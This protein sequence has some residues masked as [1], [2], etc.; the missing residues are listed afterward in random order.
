MSRNL[1]TLIFLVSFISNIRSQ[2]IQGFVADSSNLG[3]YGIIV[4]AISQNDTTKRKDTL[5]D[6]AGAYILKDIVTGINDIPGFTGDKM[7]I[8]YD[9]GQMRINVTSNQNI[10]NGKLY[11]ITGQAISGAQFQRIGSN[12][13]QAIMNIPGVPEQAVL[14][15]DGVH[16]AKKIIPKMLPGYGT[17]PIELDKETEKSRLK[18]API[19]EETNFIFRLDDP[20]EVDEYQPIEVVKS[21]DMQNTNYFDFEMQKWPEFSSNIFFNLEDKYG[22]TQKNTNININALDGTCSFNLQTDNNGAAQITNITIPH[23][24]GNK[25]IPDS[26]DFAVEI[27]ANDYLEMTRDTLIKV[28][29]GNLI[30]NYHNL[31]P[32]QQDFFANNYATIVS[33]QTGNPLQNVL[34]EMWKENSTDT[35]KLVSNEQGKVN[36]ENLVIPPFNE[37]TPDT[38]KYYMQLSKD[39]YVSILDSIMISDGDYV[40]NRVLSTAYSEYSIFINSKN[41][42]QED[43]NEVEWT[44]YTPDSIYVWSGNTGINSSDTVEIIIPSSYT[45]VKIH[46]EKKYYK[47][48]DSKIELNNSNT[49]TIT[50]NEFNANIYSVSI[51]SYEGALVNPMINYKLQYTDNEIYN[52]IN[53]ITN[54]NGYDSISFYSYNDSIQLIISSSALHFNSF[55]DTVIIKHAFDTIKVYNSVERFITILDIKVYGDSLLQQN[56]DLKIYFKNIS[57]TIVKL[58]DTITRV[59]ASDVRHRFIFADFEGFKLKGTYLSNS[60]TSTARYFLNVYLRSDCSE[61]ILGRGILQITPIYQWSE[62][63]DVVI[64][65]PEMNYTDSFTLID[66]NAFKKIIPVLDSG[67]TE[68][69]LNYYPKHTSSDKI[70]FYNFHKTVYVEPNTYNWGNDT[71][72]ALEQQQKIK[73]K[74]IYGDTKINAT[75]VD[76]IVWNTDKTQVVD[77]I[78]TMNGEFEFGPYSVGFSGFMDIHI[79]ESHPERADTLY[80][81]EKGIPLY[82]AD[83]SNATGYLIPIEK[84]TNFSDSIVIYNVFLTPAFWIDAETGMLAKVNPAHLYRMFGT[85]HAYDLTLLLDDT[86]NYYYV[87]IND[88]K[89][90]ENKIY[91]QNVVKEIENDFG[92]SFKIKEVHSKFNEFI[93]LTSRPS[94]EGYFKPYIDSLKANNLIGLNIQLGGGLNYGYG[95]VNFIKEDVWTECVQ[96]VRIPLPFVNPNDT[97]DPNIL[98]PYKFTTYCRE[99]IHR[100]FNATN[101]PE[102]FYISVGNR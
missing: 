76:I 79:P 16:P 8:T 13:F 29:Q 30:K 43:L 18:S 15:S 46:S 23:I 33:E 53:G 11:T 64:E 65:I 9:G 59:Y 26:I 5:T 54:I 21:V 36:F 82:K 20:Q 100:R 75:Y 40:V 85:G 83:Y 39:G 68:V 80:F 97:R 42:N 102:E 72:Q 10:Q 31:T 12:E 27:P 86:I 99:F 19:N 17:Q 14:F 3:I 61:T 77:S 70:P 66:N 73:G 47:N 45:F 94:F 55:K 78:R 71:L 52:E 35:L 7:T 69:V 87:S 22:N 89:M 25:R 63:V 98:T 74:I 95:G 93:I 32:K 96:Y 6:F 4:E 88:L 49:T 84:I 1:L 44:L 58:N 38:V 57:S 91:L 62:P 48:W 81:G 28:S 90:E 92:I 24:E 34:A 37:I 101:I 56:Q 41:E 50:I 60:F 67:L 2:V 51:Y